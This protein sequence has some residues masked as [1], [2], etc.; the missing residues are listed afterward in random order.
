MMRVKEEHRLTAHAS[1]PTLTQLE[2]SAQLLHGNA[3]PPLPPS[4]V[5]AMAMGTKTFCFFETTFLMV[6]QGEC[7]VC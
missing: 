6:R 7:L 3:S 1:V 4:E 5:Q 2:L